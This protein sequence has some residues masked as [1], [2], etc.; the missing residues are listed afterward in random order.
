MQDRRDGEEHDAAKCRGG[1][2]SC[3][4]REE[5]GG[6]CGRGQR[7]REGQGREAEVE[8]INARAQG[9][10]EN[11]C[12]GLFPSKKTPEGPLF[13]PGPEP[14]NAGASDLPGINGRERETAANLFRGKNARFSSGWVRNGHRWVGLGTRSFASAM[15]EMWENELREDRST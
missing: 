3:E 9:P 2:I 1:S 5:L 11:H 12:R 15:F 7:L 10:A 13:V 8:R 6:E 4:L 14:R